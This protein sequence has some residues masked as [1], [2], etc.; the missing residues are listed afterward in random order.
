MASGLVVC[1]IAGLLSFA[2]TWLVRRHASRLGLVQAPNVRS[3]HSV[4]TPGGGGLGIVLGGAVATLYALP[5]AP[6][7]VVTAL[8]ASLAL[9]AVGFWDDRAPL[10]PGLRLLAQAAL[11]LLV[12]L[13]SGALAPLAPAAGIPVLLLL[14]GLVLAGVYWIN[15]FNFMDGI[16]GLAGSQAVFM[17]LGAAALALAGGATGGEAAGLWWLAGI[18][19]ATLGFLL[20]NWPPAT[21]FMG[22][23]GSTWLG[24]VLA[25]L[26]LL[27]VSW[28]WLS[29]WQWLILGAAFLTD[30]SVTLGRRLLR[31]ERVFEAHRRHA[32]Q[33]LAR[34]WR[35]H[36]RVTLL[37]IAIDVAWL[38]PLAAW[39]GGAGWPAAALAYAPLVALALLAGAG[40]P[41]PGS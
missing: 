11:W 26:A 28:G 39:A 3:S 21:I 5:A 12:V 6:V 33:A 14:A 31:R 35:S 13:A 37:F 1:L 25:A 22:D 8:V 17:L 32:Y 36:R 41:E 38:L 23:V 10:H 4:P 2:A 15:L 20:L 29:A 30:A 40:A 24:F 7:P 16:D 19:A 18:A 34:R 27:T 9:A